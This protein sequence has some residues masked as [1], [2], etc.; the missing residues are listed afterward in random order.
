V[1][2][3]V[4]AGEKDLDKMM[5]GKGRGRGRGGKGPQKIEVDRVLHAIVTLVRLW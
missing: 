3:F 2:I 4:R 5:K 1:C